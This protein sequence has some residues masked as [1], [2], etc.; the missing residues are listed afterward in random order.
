M[1]SLS[2]AESEN[3]RDAVPEMLAQLRKAYPAT[4]FDAVRPSE[5]PGLFEVSMGH[6]V[7]YVESKGRYFLF[8]HLYD[9]PANDDITARR[10]SEL[11]SVKSGTL[12]LADG[13]VMRR[14]EHPKQKLAIFSDPNCGYCRALE[15]TLAT[16]PDIEVTVY[17]LPLQEGS[18]EAAANV[19]CAPDRS[20]AWESLMLKGKPQANAANQAKSAKCDTAVFSRNRALAQ[21]LGIHGT[22]ALIANDGRMQPGFLNRPEL[23]AWLNRSS[24]VTV[25]EPIRQ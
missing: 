22:P 5:I 14:A 4:Q 20:V 24:T 6:N 10:Q 17:L 2:M 25:M 3:S 12:P 19:W 18:E 1:A 8:G 16:L 13:I 7:A 9:L 15:K 11:V 21:Q 23:L